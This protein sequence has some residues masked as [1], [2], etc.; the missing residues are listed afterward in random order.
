MV[1]F[2]GEND[3]RRV[4]DLLASLLTHLFSLAWDLGHDL[5]PSVSH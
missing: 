1:A 2:L 4:E 5:L 3:Q